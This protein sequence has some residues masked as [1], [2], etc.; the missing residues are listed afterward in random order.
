LKELILAFRRLASH[1]HLVFLGEG[2]MELELQDLVREEHLGDRVHFLKPVPPRDLISTIVEADLAAVI[3]RGGDCRS[4]YYSLPNKLFEAI[5]AGLPLVASDL[6]EIRD[7]VATYEIGM[8]CRP[9]D[10]QDIARAIEEAL[11]P[12]RYPTF[13]ANL[14]RAQQ[15]LSWEKESQKLARLY[16]ALVMKTEGPSPLS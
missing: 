11:A 7:I 8:L 4:Y 5:A 9:E 14:E 10:P 6:P 15:D 16:Q 3:I 12:D 2:P 1:C 13:K